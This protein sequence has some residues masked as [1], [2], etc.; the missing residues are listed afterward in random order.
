MTC[1]YKFKKEKEDDEVYFDDINSGSDYNYQ[2]DMFDNGISHIGETV[3]NKQ[4][5]KMA[6]IEYRNV[7]NIT[8]KFFEDNT[9]VANKTYKN[10]LKGYI[11]N[12]NFDIYKFTRLRETN[13]ANNG[14]VMT[15]IEYINA[16]NITVQFDDGMIVKNK[17]YDHFK[18]GK[19]S[20]P[21]YRIGETNIATNGQIMTI[22]DYQG[23]DNITVQFEDKT[24][25]PHKKYSD[26]KKGHILNP[27]C[28]TVYYKKIKNREGETSISSKGQI[29]KIIKYRSAEDLDIEFEDG[30]VVEHKT[31][32]SFQR[33]EIRNPN[34]KKKQ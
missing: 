2:N 7:N 20:N 30:T 4:G 33:G 31:Y 14:Q 22:V 8:V 18:R 9:I 32:I 24:V 1:N 16:D 10:F 6:I 26:F 28:R 29:M 27:N 5:L 25:V 21:N 17:T 3:I 23:T 12:P 19:I 34:Y 11:E 13:I 15:I